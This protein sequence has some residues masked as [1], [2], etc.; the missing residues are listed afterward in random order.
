MR[1]DLIA[2]LTE[3]YENC[4]SDKIKE[5]YDSYDGVKVPEDS[6]VRRKADGTCS[7]RKSP[8][9]LGSCG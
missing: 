3:V 7:T 8:T 5:I 6:H 4:A 9:G 2:D 1:T